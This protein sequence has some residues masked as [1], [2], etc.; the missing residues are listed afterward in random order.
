MNRAEAIEVMAQM[1]KIFEAQSKH[2]L[3]EYVRKINAKRVEALGYALEEIA[4]LERLEK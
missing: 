3:T 2:G 1:R 4:R